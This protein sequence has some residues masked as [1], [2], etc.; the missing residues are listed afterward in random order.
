MTTFAG[1]SAGLDA[2]WATLLRAQNVPLVDT[3]A[4]LVSTATTAMAPW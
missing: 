4:E 2:R 1:G 3:D